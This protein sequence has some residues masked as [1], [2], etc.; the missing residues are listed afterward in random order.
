MLGDLPLPKDA[1]ISNED[2]LVLGEGDAWVGRVTIYCGLPAN[3]T[4]AFFI[5]KYPQAGWTLLSSTK[6]KVSAL[7]FVN[8]KKTALLEISEESSIT[9]SAKIVM[10]VSPLSSKVTVPKK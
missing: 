8:T 6:S 10:T 1:R 2:S 4:V 9:K 3:E 5:E 7:V